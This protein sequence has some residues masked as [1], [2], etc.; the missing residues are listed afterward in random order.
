MPASEVNPEFRFGVQPSGC[1]D[2]EAG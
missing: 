2:S 1:T